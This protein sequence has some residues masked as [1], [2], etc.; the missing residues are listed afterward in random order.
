MLTGEV[1]NQI[2]RIWDQFWSGGISNPLEVIEQIT[3]L[4]F[5]R[6]LDEIQELEERKAARTGKTIE[7]VI[8]PKG[9]DA[10]GTPYQNLRWSK[11]KLFDARER[12]EVDSEHV[13]RFPR[14]RV[15]DSCSMKHRKK[16]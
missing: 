15:G 2:D 5:M 12:Y 3:Y 14:T 6:R 16:I 4:L 8:F 1:R 10:K 7:R 11:F 9:K 13:F